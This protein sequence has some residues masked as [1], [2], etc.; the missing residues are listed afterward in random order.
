MSPAGSENSS[1]VPRAGDQGRSRDATSCTGC[2][3]HCARHDPHDK[4]RL[5]FDDQARILLIDWRIC[6]PRIDDRE[7]KT[8]V[9][10]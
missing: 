1:Q 8:T 3:E 10:G 2:A 4:P 7:S 6:R 9:A 5:S